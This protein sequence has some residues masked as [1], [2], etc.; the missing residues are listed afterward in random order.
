MNEIVLFGLGDARS[1][2]ID[3]A[4]TL[5]ESH[6]GLTSTA[7]TGSIV[8]FDDFEPLEE[9]CTVVFFLKKKI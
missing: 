5:V 1:R 4:L 9:V 6:S 7:T 3:L 8:V 2:A